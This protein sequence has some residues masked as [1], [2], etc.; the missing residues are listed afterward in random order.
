MF[1]TQW[2][3]RW[4]GIPIDTVKCDWRR[5]LA[6]Y[7]AEAIRLAYESMHREARQFPPNL[8]EFSALCRQFVRR[9]AHSLVA[10]ADNRRDP[11][12]QGFQSL[13]D[14]LSKQRTTT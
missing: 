3:D 14:L 1:G 8:S 11:P 7:D 6:C 9:G 4:D 10:I 2:L 5:A 13:K 12:P